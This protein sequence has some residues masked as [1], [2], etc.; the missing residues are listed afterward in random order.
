[1]EKLPLVFIASTLSF[2]LG[3]IAFMVREYLTSGRIEKKA[4][5]VTSVDCQAVRDKCCVG[6]VKKELSLERSHFESFRR[7]VEVRL[8][9]VEKRLDQG[10]ED[11][12]VIR[13]DIGKINNTLARMVVIL[14][15]QSNKETA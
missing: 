14:E 13:K 5:Y 9:A 8:M 12:K 7:E 2:G 1:M 4:V 15:Q 6:D 11:F 10:R 3:L